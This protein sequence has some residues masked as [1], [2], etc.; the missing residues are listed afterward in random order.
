V[1]LRLEPTGGFDGAARVDLY[2]SGP[3]VSA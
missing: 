1:G 3:A 2:S